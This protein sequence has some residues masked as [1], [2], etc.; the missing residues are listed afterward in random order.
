MKTA[1]LYY[2]KHHGN[3]FRLLEAIKEKNEVDL[4]DVIND[5]GRDLSGYDRIGLA[6]GVYAGNLGKT[7]LSYAQNHLPE[8]KEVFYIY[9]SASTQESALS[10]I[11][12]IVKSKGCK[13]IGTYYS[14]GYNTFGPFKL[15]G[16]TAKG[17]PT[18]DEIE[19]AVA[20][21]QGL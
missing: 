15:V 1:I 21:Y 2:S 6:S 5:K 3:T 12:Q 20:F 4:I 14:R 7:L 17:H 11:R 10:K 9:T 18:Q 13:E 16:G 19:K 8:G